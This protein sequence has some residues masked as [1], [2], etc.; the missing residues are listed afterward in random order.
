VRF[1]LIAKELDEMNFDR[2]VR[3]LC[4]QH[5]VP[6][7]EIEKRSELGCIAGQHR[8]QETDETFLVNEKVKIREGGAEREVVK[9]VSKARKVWIPRNVR[10]CSCAAVVNYGADKEAGAELEER[11]L[12][13][14]KQAQSIAEETEQEEK[15]T[16]KAGKKGKSKH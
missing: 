2:L 7:I 12:D 8:L 6:L 11:F 13:D 10:P 9:K 16:K 4:V 15:E 14:I 1:C 5:K 3:A